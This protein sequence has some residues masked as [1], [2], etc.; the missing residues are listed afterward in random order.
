MRRFVFAVGLVCLAAS[1][2]ADDDCYTQIILK[3]KTGMKLKLTYVV[4]EW[5]KWDVGPPIDVAKGQEIL[6]KAS[7]KTP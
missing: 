1:A 4:L 3:N 5:G 6:Y 2:H 7:G